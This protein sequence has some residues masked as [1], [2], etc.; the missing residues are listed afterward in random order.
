MPWVQHSTFGGGGEF[1]TPSSIVRLLTEVIEPYH[2]RILG[3]TTLRL[4]QFN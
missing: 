3:K 4:A 2:E 1:Y